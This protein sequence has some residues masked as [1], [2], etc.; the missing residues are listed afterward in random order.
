MSDWW[1]LS[2]FSRSENG[3]V[4]FSS[5]RSAEKGGLAPWHKAGLAGGETPPPRCLS[6]FFRPAW[7]PG[8]P[9]VH[10]LNRLLRTCRLP[11]FSAMRR[12][13]RLRR[14]AARDG[15]PAHLL[16]ILNDMKKILLYGAGLALAIGGPIG[17]FSTN[18][19]LAGVRKSWFSTS[20]ATA[21][22]PSQPASSGL[23]AGTSQ[24]TGVD[25]S[26]GAR[27]NQL[28]RAATDTP[29]LA[30]VLR[31]DVTVPWVTQH[32]PRVSSGLSEVRLQGYRVPLVTGAGITDVAGSLTY[33]FDARQQ[34]QRIT[35]R[36]TTGNPTALVELLRSRFHF[37]RR[38]VNDPGLILFEAVDPNNQPAGSLKIRSAPV[39][40]ANQPYTRYEVDLVVDRPQ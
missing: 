30:D 4:P 39:I 12:L 25:K 35:L 26:H 7:R 17:L 38:L 16:P 24:E 28:G 15:K 8:G 1:G 19:F 20:S 37:T 14:R 22:A 11:D 3:T 6:P 23:Y 36:G 18:G 13:H 10:R 21:D 34:A 27:G 5:P 31:F 29:G 9:R 40:K 32:W 2:R 33:Y